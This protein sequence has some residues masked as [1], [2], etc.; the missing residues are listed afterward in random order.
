VYYCTY[1]IC[2][3]YFIPLLL[4][5]FNYRNCGCGKKLQLVKCGS[6]QPLLCGA[7]CGKELNC[8]VHHC[9]N[10]CHTGNCPECQE[11]VIQGKWQ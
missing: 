8:G 3:G 4:F 11:K 2:A 1:F 5:I 7:V 9:T 6:D 10:N